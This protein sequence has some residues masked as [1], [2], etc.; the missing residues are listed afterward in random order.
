MTAAARRPAVAPVAGALIVAG[1]LAAGCGSGGSTAPSPS[2]AA[3]ASPATP[4]ST[5]AASSAAPASSPPLTTSQRRKLARQYL[6]VAGPA[7]KAL[8]HQV[9][10]FDDAR[11]DDLARAVAALRGQAVTERGFD[12]KLAAIDFPAP[13]DTTA[14]LLIQANQA[15]IALTLREA[16]ATSLARLATFRKRHAAADAAVERQVRLLRKQLGLPPPDTS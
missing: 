16:G 7:N 14:G 8:D 11:H 3:P 2:P 13:L 9:D 6:A 10:A 5:A 15:R 12:R 1:I 4:A